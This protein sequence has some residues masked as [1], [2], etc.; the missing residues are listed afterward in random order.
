MTDFFQFTFSRS[1]GKQKHK[2]E[3][4]VIRGLG[5]KVTKMLFSHIAMVT[6]D[7]GFSIVILKPK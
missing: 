2:L 5:I 4:G 1:K 3:D 7:H 6:N